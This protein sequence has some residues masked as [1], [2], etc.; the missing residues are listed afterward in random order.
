MQFLWKYVEDMVGKGVEMKILGEMFFYAA[1]STV[2]LSL[3]LAILLASLMTFGE[4][5]EHLELLAMK[6]SGISLIRIMKPLIIFV[7]FVSGIAFV[8]QNNILP[9]AQAKLWTIVLSLRQKSP[10]LDIPEASFYK[11]ITGY[12][13]FV[14]KK[15]KNGLLHDMTIY[16]YTHGFDASVVIVADSGRLKMSNDKKYLVLT[17]YNGESFQNMGTRK[18]RYSQNQIPYRRDTFSRLDKLI[19][20]DSNFN[21]AD[22]SI[23]QNRDISKNMNELIS[24]IDSVGIRNDSIV[25]GLSPQFIKRVYATT[26]KQERASHPA[27]TNKPD[28]T[29]SGDFE[30][31]FKNMPENQQLSVLMDAKNKA[32]RINSDYLFQMNEQSFSQ[33]QLR[34]HQ[35]ELHKKFTLSLACLL[36]FFIGAPLGAIIRKGGLGMPAVISVFLFILY[37]TIDTF[38]TKMAKQGV[39]PV[40]EGMWMS[41]LLLLS[42][43]IFLTYKA[44]NDSVIMNPDAWGEI[45][46]RLLGKREVRNYSRKEVIMTPP[47]Y[48]KDLRVI[49]DWNGDANQ[50]LAEF[51]K[52]PFYSSFW[53]MDF[54][55]RKLKRLIASMD[56]WIEDLRNSKENLIIGK[57]MDYPVISPVSLDFLNKPLFRWTCAILLPIGLTLYIFYLFRQK[58]INSDLRLALKV[59]EELK[60]ELKTIETE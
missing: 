37:Y 16:D 44:V 35:I 8:F 56:Q 19:E 7:I 25:K 27:N 12:S 58:R 13:V 45:L 54:H 22:E 11:E 9:P 17:L 48:R 52:L 26:F 23:M 57:I 14:H 36:F 6:S 34:G 59:N 30:L 3:P 1:I 2:P 33:R 21:L 29:Y 55:D 43:G 49:E 42:L 50:Y 31:F 51:Q 41:S 32:E 18:S 4:M 28:S 15:D 10:E 46:Q 39:W 53:K 40:W 38:G 47:D 24:F 60:K 5:G 20:F